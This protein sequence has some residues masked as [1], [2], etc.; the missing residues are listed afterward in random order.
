MPKYLAFKMIRQLTLKLENKDMVMIWKGCVI[1]W[2]TCRSYVSNG[3]SSWTP[4]GM[5][6]KPRGLMH[7]V[8]CVDNF[9]EVLFGVHFLLVRFL[10]SLSIQLVY[11]CMWRWWWRRW[12]LQA[13]TP[14]FLSYLPDVF[15]CLTLVMFQKLL[16]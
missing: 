13:L 16:R 1:K 12:V 11:S 3:N 15:H 5:V 8:D 4:L 9:D 10:R 7:L 6:Q 2:F 14:F